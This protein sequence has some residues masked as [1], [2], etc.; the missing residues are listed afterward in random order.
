[1]KLPYQFVLFAIFLSACASSPVTAP[2]KVA[3]IPTTV[4]ATLAD[5]TAT[6]TAV[7]PTET[8]VAPTETATDIPATAT[9]AETATSA[10]T[11][12]PTAIPTVDN[13]TRLERF[14]VPDTAYIGKLAITAAEA[15]D[16]TEPGAPLDAENIVLLAHVDTGSCLG[17]ELDIAVIDDR[18]LIFQAGLGSTA[19]IATDV[20]TP[21][22]PR[23]LGRWRFAPNSYASDLRYF[24][25]GD[26][27]YVSISLEGFSQQAP[28][29]IAIVNVTDLSAPTLVQHI[30]G[31]NVGSDR[32]WC[33]VHTAPVSMDEN[34]D[35]AF[36]YASVDDTFDL[37][38]VDIRDLD[39]PVEVNSYQHANYTFERNGPETF[40]HDSTIVGDRVYVSY[41]DGGV[42]ILDRATVEAGAPAAEFVLNAPN[43]IDPF[44]FLVH[45]AYPTENEDFL[46]IEDELTYD[47]KFSQLRL[48]DIRD[49]DNPAA[50][51]RLTIPDAAISPH[52][53][54]VKDD[55]LF[56]GWYTNGVQVFRYDVSDPDNATV[57]RIAWHAVRT[58]EE[59]E[60]TFDGV[61]GVRLNDCTVAGKETT[62][63]YA[64]DISN[65]LWVMALEE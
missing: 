13:L 62:C 26:Q 12:P 65:G 8:T 49:L 18:T 42:M 51:L 58:A 17:G 14:I 23:V 39:N 46:F 63:I 15:R 10:P 57:E 60:T 5:P 3:E 1:M 37:R 31:L 43:S 6:H 47:G 36:L 2:T 27:H 7:A 38:V 25:Q 41:W 61:W 52:N 44:D 4:A 22:A 48:W 28:C 55:L 20:T 11:T 32:A 33:N 64:S 34:G 50:V 40:V 30:Q 45:H 35:G 56:V 16:C 29:G 53:L 9:N 59:I 21:T 24:S 54:L 19:F